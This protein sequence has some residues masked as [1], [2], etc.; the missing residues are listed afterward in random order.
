MRVSIGSDHAGYELKGKLKD[1]LVRLGHDVRDEGTFG[2]E[3]VDYPDTASRVARSVQIGEADRGVLVCGTGIGM[4]IA[5]NKFRGIRAA[6]CHNLETAVL[7]REHNDANVL[8]LS[9]RSTHDDLA[10][11]MVETWLKTDFLG[12]RHKRR[13]DKIGQIEANNFR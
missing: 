10:F 4:S 12:D 5:A 8:T 2:P 9:G 3:S 7:S 1:L 13:V 11:K 6:V